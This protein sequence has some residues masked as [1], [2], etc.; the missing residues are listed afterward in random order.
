MDPF[1]DNAFYLLVWR[2]FLAVLIAVVLMVT[3]SFA[4]RAALLIGAN[5]ALVLSLGLIVRAGRIDDQRVIRTAAWRMVPPGQRPA[6]AAG[7]R[8]AGN[9]LREIDLR[10]AQ[11]ASVAAIALAASALVAGA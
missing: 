2:A 9:H 4:P 3:M 7:R 6:G 8:W 10:F 11:F 5:A 1:R